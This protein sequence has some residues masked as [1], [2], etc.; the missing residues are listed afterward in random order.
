MLLGDSDTPAAYFACHM[1]VQT[2]P[3]DPSGSAAPASNLIFIL[4]AQRSGTTWLGKIF[5]SHPGILYRHEPDE[6]VAAPPDLTDRALPGVLNAWI[7]HRGL[8]SAAKMPVF[9]KDWE[10]GLSHRARLTIAYL[11]TAAAHLPALGSFAARLPVPDFMC[12]GQKPGPRAAI[13]SIRWCDGVGR[14][15]RLYP[16]SRTLL[17]V[18]HPCGQVE[19]VM[20]GASQGRFAA[21]GDEG[22]M[23]YHEEQAMACAR[24][25]GVTPSAFRAL[26]DA[27]KYAWAWVAFNEIAFEAL[28]GR[29]NARIVLY[30]DLCKQ[31]DTLSRELFAFAGLPWCEQS[32][33]FVT[34]SSHHEGEAAY[35]A[36]YRNAIAAAENWRK[37]MKPEDQAAVLAVA[38]Q[39]PL[40]RLWPDVCLAETV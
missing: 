6:V 27:A 33:A 1:P 22:G 26:P 38:A 9:R 17:I 24:R 36:V 28:D 11:I 13:K 2:P 23:P 16:D 4:G 7:N 37:R 20:R 35:Y 12:N 21:G 5:D 31:P 39:S 18:R 34:T 10:T 40:A 30:E 14:L 29:P 32:S 25:R 8:R 3:G 19:S 15:A